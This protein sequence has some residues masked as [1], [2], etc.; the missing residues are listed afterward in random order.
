MRLKQSKILEFNDSYIFYKII[1][2]MILKQ[3][4][5]VSFK[6]SPWTARVR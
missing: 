1:I 3:T 5:F 4:S 2:I 6:E